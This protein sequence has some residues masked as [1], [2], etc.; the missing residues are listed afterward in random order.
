M[1]KADFL[2]IVGAS[3]GAEYVPV[4]GLLQNGYSFV[5][6]FNSRVSED[7]ADTLVLI[8][9]RLMDLREKPAR[10]SRPRISDFN[11]FVE[12]IVVQSYESGQ[13][14]QCTRSDI[15]GKSIPLI[16]I[17]FE[18]VAVVYPI[19]QIG[20]M[21]AQLHHEQQ[22]APSFFDFENKSLV[23]KILRTTLW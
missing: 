17:P 1:K 4:A 3:E 18:Q 5:G 23:L 20:K 9:A 21:M 14:P 15:Y 11:E 2:R 19:V 7:V 16:A 22:R 10:R 8:N 13:E 6:Y 12:E